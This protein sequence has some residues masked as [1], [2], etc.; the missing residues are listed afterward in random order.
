MAIGNEALNGRERASG[1]VIV[2]DVDEDDPSE[3]GD[4]PSETNEDKPVT[5]P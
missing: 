4:D 5:L 2:E 1:H 3:Q